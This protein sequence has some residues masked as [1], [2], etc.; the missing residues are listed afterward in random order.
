MKNDKSMCRVRVQRKN[1]VVESRTIPSLSPVSALRE[2]SQ[3]GAMTDEPGRQC[4][5]ESPS[6]KSPG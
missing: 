3:P 2:Q 6:G 4:C 1:K 5:F